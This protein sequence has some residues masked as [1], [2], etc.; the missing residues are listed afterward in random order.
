MFAGAKS[1]NSDLSK[2]DVGRVINMA[3][4]FE[5]SFAFNSDLSNWDVANVERM[6]LMFRRSILFNKDI[7]SW[8][9]SKV[10][11]TTAMF[12]LAVSFDQNLCEWG[13]KL[14]PGVETTQMFVASGCANKT[15][16]SFFEDSSSSSGPWCQSCDAAAS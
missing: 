2:W 8:N 1:F 3:S 9:V 4:M 10:K 5:E 7:S 12:K 14:P 16:P 15:E 13:Q 6:D 11:N